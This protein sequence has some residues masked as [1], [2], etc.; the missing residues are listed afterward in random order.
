MRRR[1]GPSS[2][3]PPPSL[4]IRSAWAPLL[5]GRAPI[6]STRPAGALRC[7]TLAVRH[8]TSRRRATPTMR[9]TSV[10]LPEELK[11]RL[12]LLARRTG[13]SEAQ[14]LRVAVER[15]VADEPSGRQRVAQA[16]P[17]VVAPPAGP[18]LVGVGRRPRRPRARHPPGGRGAAPGR[19]GRGPDDVRAGGRPG[20]GHRPR[21]RARGRRRAGQLRD[22]GRH[23]RPGG[24]PR[25]RRRPHR[26]PPRRG[27]AGGLRDPRRP[28]ASTARSGRWPRRCGPAGPTCRSRW[29]PGSWRSRTWPPAPPRCSSTA[30]STSCWS[31]PTRQRATPP[32]A[33]AAA[34]PHA[35]RRRL[36]GRAPRSERWPRRWPSTTGST[37][38]CS[39]SCSACP[40]GRVA[41]VAEVADRPASYLATLIVPPVRDEGGP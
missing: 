27:R 14:L 16:E 1:G 37:A 31:R 40:G 26:R 4:H 11:D 36:Q 29:C 34:D 38:R 2:P 3:R 23:R 39:A 18:A 21:R 5:A 32:L 30:P 17:A 35:A 8:G 9:K 41:P 28:R 7:P 19:P 24:G 33:A 6:P 13:R 15:L 12:A 20:R 25:C 10:Y 22:G